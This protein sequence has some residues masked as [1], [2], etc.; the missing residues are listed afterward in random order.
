MN[1]WHEI[2][3]VRDERIA[4]FVQHN[5][6]QLLHYY[7]P[8]AG[9]FIAESPTV[10]E[11]ALA[12]GYEPLAFLIETRKL[13]TEAIPFIKGYPHVPVFHGTYEVLKEI[14][15]FGLTRG[16]LAAMRRK[17]LSYI[18]DIC[19]NKKRVVVMEDVVNPTNVGAI[20]RSAAAL[21]MDAVILT[22]ACSDPYY[23]RALRVG[24]GNALL[25]PWT[26]E[27]NWLVK[28]HELGYKT[29]A[30]ALTDESVGIDNPKLKAEEK[31]AIILGTE[32][33]GLKDETIKACDYTVKIP[34]S[35]GVDSLNVA[36]ASAV[37]FW[38]LG[39]K[40]GRL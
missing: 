27:D 22:K 39:R 33:A 4:W 34:M 26:I 37:A 21:D 40:E 24:M 31:L 7:E 1:N 35:N 38:E 28:L 6:S 20:F 36:A 23:R 5:E 16:M 10:I 9:I 17:E 18:A 11:R 8:E 29:A 25:I 30:M 2:E 14:T 13:E 12:C 3:D 32:G 19:K 15:G